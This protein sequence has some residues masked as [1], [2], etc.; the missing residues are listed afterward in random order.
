MVNPGLSELNFSEDSV[1]RSRGTSI[2]AR[3]CDGDIP[4]SLSN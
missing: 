1:D 2:G 4:E 3:E